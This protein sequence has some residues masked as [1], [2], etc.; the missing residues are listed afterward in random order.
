MRT[1]QDINTALDS[2][3]H[4]CKPLLRVA[5]DGC[6]RW[7]RHVARTGDTRNA[8]RILVGKCLENACAPELKGKVRLRCIFWTQIVSMVSGW[9]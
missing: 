4:T 5:T 6:V 3:A 7:A 9:N 2:I 1:I 8:Y